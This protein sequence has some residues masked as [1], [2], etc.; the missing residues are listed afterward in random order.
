VP[1]VKN[2]LHS[3]H[4]IEVLLVE[5]D[6]DDVRLMRKTLENDHFHITTHR[7]EDGVEAM[8]YLR[9]EGKFADAV[10][11]DLILLDLNMPRKDGRAV[12]KEIKEADDL[13]SIPV[14]VLTSSDD[15]RDIIECYWHKANSFITK[16]VDLLRIRNV[17]EILKDYWF[18]IVKLPP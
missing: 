1:A 6:D 11:P 14:V 17:L 3:V 7:V 13:S 8:A 2:S 16:P 9:R 15:E 10:R 4:P 18:S 5:D 12:L